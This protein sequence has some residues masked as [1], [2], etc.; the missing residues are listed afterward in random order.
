M[1]SYGKLWGLFLG[2][3]LAHA[4]YGDAFVAGR[5]LKRG[6]QWQL[7]VKTSA[8]ERLTQSY[9]SAD[10]LAADLFRYWLEPLI[11]QYAVAGEGEFELRVAGL[12]GQGYRQLIR[13]LRNSSVIDQAFPTSSTADGVVLRVSTRLGQISWNLL[14]GL[15]MTPGRG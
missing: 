11:D 2:V 10:A 12:D 14:A 8:G 13:Y 15:P 3:E 1:V 6:Q 4:R 5:A 7:A 9:L